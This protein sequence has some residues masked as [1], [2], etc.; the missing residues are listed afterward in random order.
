MGYTDGGKKR[1]VPAKEC[2]LPS[3]FTLKGS[4]LRGFLWSL[5]HV[6]G[7]NYIWLLH[8]TTGEITC[9]YS[10]SD[11]TLESLCFACSSPAAPCLSPVAWLWLSCLD[12]PPQLLFL[13]FLWS[14]SPPFALYQVDFDGCYTYGSW[15]SIGYRKEM[16]L[17]FKV[18]AWTGTRI[19]EPH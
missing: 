5:K 10:L 2:K 1:E 4:F 18:M 19:D 8:F 6:V 14:P 12:H 9:P 11:F 7:C 17:V 16:Y 13:F 15:L 3:L